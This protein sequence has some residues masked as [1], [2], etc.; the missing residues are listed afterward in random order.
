M[1][2]KPERIAALRK[3]ADELDPRRLDTGT[4]EGE[5][6]RAH[7]LELRAASLEITDGLDR[8]TL[9]VRDLDVRPNQS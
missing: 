4:P 8:L 7:R 1:L 6:E 9:A 3:T 5:R 2:A